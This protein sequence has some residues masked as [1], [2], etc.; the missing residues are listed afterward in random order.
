MKWDSV[1]TEKLLNQLMTEPERMQAELI[2]G[3]SAFSPS[4]P[5]YL[6]SLLAK[7]KRTIQQVIA[8]SCLSKAFVYQ[9]F[10]GDRSP[11]R[12][13]MLRIAFALSLTLE[14]TQRMLTIGNRPILYPKISRDAA[15]ICC[16]CQGFSLEDTS[17]F[18]ESI[19]ER[20]L[21]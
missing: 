10:S 6:A 11:G 5:G 9:I 16:L 19:V 7:H 4:L 14:E 1:E 15:L 2:S 3:G 17:E 12:D 8:R 20:P 18:L 21:L 13:A